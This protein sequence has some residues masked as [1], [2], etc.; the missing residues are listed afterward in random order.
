MAEEIE[1][2]QLVLVAR[3]PCFGL[4]TACPSCLP[5]YVYLR[6]A[7]ASFDL[8]F[9]LIHPDSD[10]IPYVE[11]GEYVAYNNEKGGVIE[12]L[13]EDGVVDLDSGHPSHDAVE[14]WAI[15]RSWLTDAAMYE[16]WIGSDGS[17]AHKIY[18]S[19]LPWPIGKILHYKQARLVKQL[20]GIT[21]VNVEQKEAEIYRRASLAYVALSNKLGEQNYFLENRPRSFDAILLGHTLFTLHALPEASTLRTKLL[22]HSNLVRYT[23]NFK[24]EFLEAGSSSS[25]PRSPHEPSSSFTPKRGT[26]PNWGTKPKNKPKREKTEEEKTFKRRAKYFVATQL[27]A[28]LVFLSLLGGSDEADLDVDDDD[29]MNYDD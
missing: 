29:G 3:K 19:D 6:L 26:P 2:Q 24:T 15:V 11:Y 22:E 13:K 17:S 5:V 8:R 21:K 20:L 12:S 16:L 10:Q 28:I 1:R 9:N 27:I 23:E 25:I 4:P 14:W 18:F 7:K